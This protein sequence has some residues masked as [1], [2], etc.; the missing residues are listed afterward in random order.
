VFVWRTSD[1]TGVSREIIEHKLQ[2]N[3]HAK[4]RKQRFHKMSDEKVAAA[5]AE[6]QRLLDAGFIREVH[7]PSWLAN[8]V[9]VKKKNGK[10][11]MCIDFTDLNKSCLKDDFPLSKIDKVV[12]S[13]TTFK[14]MALLDYFS[15]YHQIWHCREDEEKTSFI[16][17][18]GTCCYL[19][20]LECL[21]NA[22]PTFCRM[23]KAILK[24]QMERNIFTYIDDIVVASRKIETQVQD[25][26]ETFANMHRAQLKLNPEKCVFGVQRGRVLG[27]LVS[28]K[29]IK[30]NPDKINA[31]VHMKPP[32]SKKEVQ[33]LIDRTTALNRFMAKL[34]DQ[35]L[36]FFKVLRGSDTF[37]WGLEQQEAFDA[38]KDYIQ[39][40]PTLASP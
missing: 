3:P 16:T 24:E 9:M 10:W 30:A 15:G 19:R 25:L 33:R 13:V 26:A 21:K 17:P 18:F 5:K 37:K 2:V 36:P 6:V 31:I 7:Y 4:P 1:L 27:C 12:D 35:S 23:M 14:I 22:S 8:V 29:G 28:V 40:L 34:V 32:G 11:R 20:M 38:L 39:K